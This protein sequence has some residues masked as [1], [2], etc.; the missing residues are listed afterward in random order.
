MAIFAA[1]RRLLTHDHLNGLV[2]RV[3]GRAQNAVWRRV[4]DRVPG[5]SIHEARGYIRARAAAV[6]DREM[7]ILAAEEPTLSPREKAELQMVV[8]H[9]LVRRLLL[10][11]LRRTNEQRSERRMAA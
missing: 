5:M 3:T 11:N 4:C 1:L 6:I 10:E 9:R 7:S 8:R 2:D